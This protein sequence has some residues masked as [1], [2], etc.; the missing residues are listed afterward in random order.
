MIKEVVELWR[1]VMADKR[2]ISAIKKLL[3]SEIEKNSWVVKS[4]K[5]HLKGIQDNWHIS[6][7][8]V[9]NAYPSK[10]RIEVKRNDGGGGGSPIYE[11]STTVFDKIVFELPVL[12]SS[13]FQL[14][15]KAYESVAEIKHVSDSLVEHILTKEEHISP[16]FIISF[17][18]YALEELDDSHQC[19][20]DLYKKC[21]GNE[22]TSHKL[23]TYT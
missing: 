10:C 21:T 7:Y 15:Q 20:A 13:L 23:R 2:K 8:K 6:D 1:R 14:A 5:Q 18:Q 19:L 4:L 17:C 16:D 9:V 22:L 11:V 3:S 12:D